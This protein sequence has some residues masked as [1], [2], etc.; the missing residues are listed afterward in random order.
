[1]NK[2]GIGRKGFLKRFI[3]SVLLIVFSLNTFSAFAAW[4]GYTESDE[5]TRTELLD[6]NNIVKVMKTG[7]KASTEH[8]RDGNM[9]SMGWTDMNS[10]TA[11]YLKDVPSDWSEYEIIELWVYSE[12][13]SNDQ[14]ALLVETQSGSDGSWNYFWTTVTVDWEGWKKVSLKLSAFTLTRNPD[15][16][17]VTQVRLASTGWNMNPNGCTTK[18]WIGDICIKKSTGISLDMIYEPEQLE[19][20]KALMLNS[21]AVYDGSPNVVVADGEVK[22]LNGKDDSV[23]AYNSGGNVM[24]PISFFKNYLGA[25]VEEKD[26]TFS[27]T[28]DDVK[29]SGKLNETAYTVNDISKAF[30]TAPEQKDGITYLS[31]EQISKELGFY[32]VTEDGLVA[33]STDETIKVLERPYGV[34]VLTEIISY[35]AAHITVDTTTLTADDCKAVKERWIYELI[36]SEADNDMSNEHIASKIKNVNDNGVKYQK[37]MIKAEDQTELFQD[38]NTSTT[39]HMTSTYEKLYKMTLAYGTYGTELY[40]NE[41]L[42]ADILYGLEW[43]Y[44][45][46][47]GLKELNGTGWRNT[48]EANWWD[49]QIGTPRSLIPI[50]LIMED[51]LTQEQIKNYLVLFDKLVP[52][53]RDEG[54]NALNT[55][56]LAIGSALLQND[57]K[58]VLRIQSG[59][60]YSF[61]YVDD[62][63]NDSQGFYTDGS[64]VFHGSHPLNGTYGLEQFQLLGPFINMFAGTKFEI[65]TPQADNISE[66]IYNAFD[67]LIY[68]GAMF[69]MVKGRYPTGMHTTGMNAMG[70][71][72]DSLDCL[73]PADAKKV[74]EIIKAQ[75]R[76]DTSIDFYSSLT[77]PQV[78]RLSKIVDDDTI[79]ARESLV[80]NHVYYNEDKVVHQRGD[81]A[82]GISMSSSRIFNYE[83]INQCNLTGWYISDGMTEYYTDGELGQSTDSYW[84]NVNPYRLPGTTV[85]T[86]ERKAVS[87]RGNMGQEYLSSKDF[88]GATSLEGTYGTAAM[89][90][91]SYH[92]ET[93]D[94]ITDVGYGGV[95]PLHN[96]NLEAKKAYF[97]FDDEVV[98]LGS[99]INASNDVEVLTVVDNKLSK[100]TKDLS[101]VVATESY[102]ILS[103][104]ASDTPE[105]EN[106]AENTIDANYGTK[107]AS[108]SDATITWDLGKEEKLGFIV[109]AFQNGSKRAQKFDLEVSSDGE[110]WDKT[111][112]GQS[113]G[114]TESG[115][116]FTLADKTARYVRFTNHGSTTGEWVSIT[117]AM[118]YA[119]NDD[120]TLSV[121]AADV[122]GDDD[123]IADGVSYDLTDEDKSIAGA[124]WAHFEH[125]GGYY[126]PEKQNLFVKYTNQSNSFMELWLSHGVNPENETYVYA[127]LPNKTAEETKAYAEN[128]DIEILANTPDL[129]VVRDKKLNV[130][131]M[132]FWKAGT[133]GDIT[134]SEPMIVMVKK[135]KNETVISACDPTHKLENA[136]IS[137]NRELRVK[138]SDAAMEITEGENTSI[139][140]NLSGSDGRSAEA[141]FENVADIERTDVIIKN[142]NGNEITEPEPDSIV[143]VS[144]NVTN[145]SNSDTDVLMLAVWYDENGYLMGC[146]PKSYTVSAKESA[147]CTVDDIELE[148]EFGKIEVF[149]WEKK[150]LS[151]IEIKTN[152]N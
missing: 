124:K 14:F 81:Y 131:G 102:T 52:T 48:G 11:L 152:T 142:A 82:M 7:A 134:V 44:N 18:L 76:D 36:G 89:W 32:T 150:S 123:F 5:V 54:S 72:L 24:V 92:R 23:C 122:I 42:K 146:K 25:D 141:V 104:E 33:I 20:A 9:Y 60:E 118:V 34:N 2:S 143:S 121:A 78:I 70:A 108:K 64:Y 38:E 101:D 80:K 95:A 99:G 137:I 91:E 86:Q 22:M 129:Q 135:N 83:S 73:K 94:D 98:C 105:P 15:F 50:L 111:F 31:A 127:L 47:Y 115:E 71:M 116:A 39:A 149:V 6:L 112:S 30:D 51:E 66:W 110:K 77:L 35:L 10:T 88:V 97:M 96:S 57:Y 109:L 56:K 67:P 125:V 17:K 58:K 145:N 75:V 74:K 28:K 37:R 130:T 79:V 40:H 140:L 138:E 87:I 114:T 4:D 16:S 107:W 90:L 84:N 53:Q 144:S 62:G 19:Q 63:R 139:T 21:V 128:P 46:R 43:L 113:S 68:Q 41:D 29:I 27:I 3:G 1:M 147:D 151:P 49:W 126:F 148:N 93:L 120:G 136:V 119:P 132:V 85:D 69:R 13:A 100:T 65:T 8:T 26:D 45:N 55:A 12:K 106:V 103:A 133:Y 117:E 59:V 61:I